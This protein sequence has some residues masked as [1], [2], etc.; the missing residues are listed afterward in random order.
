MQKKQFALLAAVVCLV[1]PYG[2]LGEAPPS[3]IHVTHVPKSRLGLSLKAVG[4]FPYDAKT[5]SWMSSDPKK[6]PVIFKPELIGKHKVPAYYEA[7]NM[8]ADPCDNSYYIITDRSYAIRISTDCSGG[9]DE[10]LKKYLRTY[11]LPE[12]VHAIRAMEKSGWEV[13]E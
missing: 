12:G 1:L 6:H 4:S 11:S 10:R 8:M 13:I 5:N 9:S 2:V 7:G 3:G